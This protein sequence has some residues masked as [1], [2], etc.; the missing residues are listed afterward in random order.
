MEPLPAQMFDAVRPKTQQEDLIDL[1]DVAK[2]CLDSL[3]MTLSGR[4]I[5]LQSELPPTAVTVNASHFHL[6]RAISNLLS[7]AIK[8]TLDEG[9]VRLELTKTNTEAVLQISDDGIGIPSEDLENVFDRFYRSANVDE[10]AIQGT[11]LGLSIVKAIVES[12][13]GSIALTSEV[14]HGTTVRLAFPLANALVPV[15]PSGK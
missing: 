4:S 11:G 9:N 1:R 8:F 10:H 3:G 2:E 5:N 15:Q 13:R 6:E 7:N 14:N 12:H